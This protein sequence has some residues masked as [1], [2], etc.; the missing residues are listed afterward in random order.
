LSADI[1]RELLDVLPGGPAVPDHLR[2]RILDAAEGN[3]LYVEEM[4]GMLVDD[5]H[6]ARDGTGTWSMASDA[7]DIAVPPT[8]SALLGSRIDALP[9]E[10][11]AVAERAAVIGRVFEVAAVRELTPE[12]QRPAIGSG[13]LALVR[14]EL[15]RP[16]RADLGTSDA[17]KFR[18][19]LIRDAAYQALPKTER[20][21]LHER[22]ADWLVVAAGDRAA[23]FDEIT[24]FHLEQ[25]HSYLLELG[26]EGARASQLAERAGEALA[27]A[28]LRAITQDDVLSARNLLRRALSLLPAASPL[29]GRALLELAS[30]GRRTGAEVASVKQL[31]AEARQTDL[32]ESQ[33]LR[34]M[35][36]EAQ[37]TT[38]S[39]LP[40]EPWIEP[41]KA[42]IAAANNVDRET[43]GQA[44]FVTSNFEWNANRPE[45][46]D[47]TSRAAEEALR[48]SSD[49]SL[50][51]ELAIQRVIQDISK[52]TPLP[53]VLVEIDAFLDQPL[54]R[55]WRAELAVE[56]GKVHLL[57]GQ[58]DRGA[59]EMRQAIDVLHELGMGPDAG[60]RK[61]D[62]GVAFKRAGRWQ[63]AVKPLEEALEYFK[64]RGS[65][66]IDFAA[67]HLAHVLAVLGDERAS[68]VLMDAG[69]STFVGLSAPRRFA[70][71]RLLSRTGQHDEAVAELTG[72][73]TTGAILRAEQQLEL[74]AA[75]EAAGSFDAAR[76]AAEEAIEIAQLKGVTV[77]VTRA[78][79]VI[80]RLAGS[81]EPAAVP[82]S[83][84]RP[85]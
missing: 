62:F 83:H 21:A 3:P 79:A 72:V 33:R 48:D 30:V 13:V 19:L 63:T 32:N 53:A 65:D 55:H 11:R 73:G 7:A 58:V 22:F 60:F 35:F 44:L 52:E 80:E 1:S 20:A 9:R 68:D 51:G 61:V 64:A 84:G 27:A 71:A 36:L 37:L 69:D 70:R 78:Q 50:L 12:A 38:D 10:E 81:T 2:R 29:R 76:T 59:E 14:K 40:G 28:G 16:E 31:V 17:F 74:S 15:I 57:G 6:L 49:M 54:S 18:H 75:H 77:F 43:L 42:A 39:R 56:R 66:D 41:L 4:L 23:E 67:A 5:G 45:D 46:A 85:T 26:V 82:S 47:Q 34:A 24:G 25:A 8:I